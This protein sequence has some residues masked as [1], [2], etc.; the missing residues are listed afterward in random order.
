MLWTLF[1]LPSFPVE[2][3]SLPLTTPLLSFCFHNLLLPVNPPLPTDCPSPHLFPTAFQ[4]PSVVAM[5]NS[6]GAF[7]C[8]NICSIKLHMLST[9]SL[10]AHVV[11]LDI[12][13]SFFFTVWFILSQLQLYRTLSP[14][15]CVWLGP[16]LSSHQFCIKVYQFLSC[17]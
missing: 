7:P 6:L 14:N 11:Q 5:F 3:T 12:L 16:F 17:D 9:V 13:R 1:Q 10:N 4:P 8:I 2:D 15:S